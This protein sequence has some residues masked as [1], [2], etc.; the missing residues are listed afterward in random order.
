M[1]KIYAYILAIK[2]LNM[3][4]GQTAF[5]GEAHVNLFSDIQ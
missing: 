2:E 5:P 1:L 4:D 3:Q